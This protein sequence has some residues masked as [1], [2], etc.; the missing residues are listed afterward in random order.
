[1][2]NTLSQAEASRALP[3]A[4]M[5]AV[6][7]LMAGSGCKTVQHQAPAVAPE[8]PVSVT[9][10]TDNS[11]QGQYAAGVVSELLATSDLITAVCGEGDFSGWIAPGA[12]SKRDFQR[13][14]KSCTTA[15]AQPSAIDCSGLRPH[16]YNSGAR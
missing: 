9:K 11:T 7:S 8:A 15:S 6:V 10:C 14:D 5:L 16:S 2:T 13:G 3:P 1:M 4:L 12:I